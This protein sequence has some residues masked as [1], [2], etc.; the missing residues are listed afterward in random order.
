LCEIEIE[1]SV[2][3]LKNFISPGIDNIP[4]E[5]I[6]AGG[7]A[8]IK[9]LHKLSAIWGKEEFPKEWKT[10]II[11]PIYKKGDKSD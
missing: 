8:L 6:K 11:V 10:S 5:L 3:K 1:M 4:A 2:K 9:V 7:T